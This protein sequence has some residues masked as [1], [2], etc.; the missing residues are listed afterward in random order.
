MGIQIDMW[1]DLRVDKRDD[2]HYKEYALIK[3]FFEIFLL[4]ILH[5]SMLLVIFFK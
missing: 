3:I 2:Q 1:G 5:N 4:Y